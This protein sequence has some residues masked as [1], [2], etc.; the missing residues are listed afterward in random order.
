MPE[1]PGL[2]S[3][4]FEEIGILPGDREGEVPYCADSGANCCNFGRMAN[5]CDLESFAKE[6]W[7]L[8]V[9]GEFEGEC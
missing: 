1:E 5:G 7:F 4:N 8:E 6:S 2:W 9:R 3:L